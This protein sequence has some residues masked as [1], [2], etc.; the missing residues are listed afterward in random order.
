MSEATDAHCTSIR[1]EFAHQGD[2]FARSPTMSLAETLD[3][4]LEDGAART[5]S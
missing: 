4:V 5:A 1:D 3:L 2:S